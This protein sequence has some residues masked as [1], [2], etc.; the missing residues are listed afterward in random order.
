MVDRRVTD[1]IR[2]ARL[3][4]SE[5]EGHGGRLAAVSVVAADPDVDPTAEGAFAYAIARD[6]DRLAEVYV[7]PDGVRVEFLVAPDRAAAAAAGRD[8]AVRR[9]D[10]TAHTL[11]AV[12][13]GAA[14]KRALRVV[15]AVA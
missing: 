8:L 13:D 3:L 4:A 15:E 12:E 1:G 5:V 6:G 11:V 7:R 9:P 14:V 2:I 10:G